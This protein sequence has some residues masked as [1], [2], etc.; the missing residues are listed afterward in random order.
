MKISLLSSYLG[1]F[2]N[3]EPS[4]S[5]MMPPA[6]A[7]CSPWLLP[8]TATA[9]FHSYLPRCSESQSATPTLWILPLALRLSTHRHDG[10]RWAHCRSV[11]TPLELRGRLATVTS[12]ST[13]C[14]LRRG[15]RSLNSPAG[16]VEARSTARWSSCF[17]YSAASSMS[18]IQSRNFSTC[19]LFMRLM[20]LP[21]EQSRSLARA[22]FLKSC[23]V[24]RGAM[25]AVSSLLPC[26]IV[27]Y[28]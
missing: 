27:K 26:M 1:I 19:F 25:F 16:I 15:L 2:S 21:P 22:S 18:S 20:V 14:F 11:L 28:G 9:L 24:T 5:S 10:Q 17:R 23:T 13:C 7:K 3:L 12:S 8:R 6:P 4:L